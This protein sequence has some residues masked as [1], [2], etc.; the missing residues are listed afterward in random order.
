MKRIIFT[1]IGICTP[2]MAEAISI[3][4]YFPCDPTIFFCG[5]QNP[6]V[7]LTANITAFVLSSVTAVAIVG[8]AYGGA[9]MIF[10]MGGEGKEAGKKAMKYAAMGLV[11]AYLSGAILKYIV[12]L[13]YAIA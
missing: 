7:E 4:N 12:Q 9:R 13:I 5:S 2:A 6:V 3:R 10:S 8:F 11:L 1:L